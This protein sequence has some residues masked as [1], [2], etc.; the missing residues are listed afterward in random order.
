MTRRTR[1]IVPF[2]DPPLEVGDPIELQD[3]GLLDGD[4]N[5]VA[6]EEGWDGEVPLVSLEL[7]Q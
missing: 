4:H 1:V 2:V 6:I 5:I 3:A 7:W